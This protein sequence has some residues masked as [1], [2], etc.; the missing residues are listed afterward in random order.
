MK[1]NYKHQEIFKGLYL[2]VHPGQVVFLLGFEDAD[3]SCLLGTIAGFDSPTRG[4]IFFENKKITNDW[5]SSSKLL[6]IRRTGKQYLY[7]RVKQRITG[8]QEKSGK[9]QDADPLDIVGLKAA[10][11]SLCRGL[12]AQQRQRLS[13]A[14][15]LTLLPRL[16]LVDGAIDDLPDADRTKI[17]KS[18][19]SSAHKN[20]MAVLYATHHAQD[21]LAFGDQTA[22]LA[23]GRILQQ[24]TPMNVYKQPG[25]AACAQLTGECILL[26]GKATAVKDETVF[27]DVA[28]LGFTCF[29]ENWISPGEPL[30]ICLRPEHIFWGHEANPG[31]LTNVSAILREHTKVPGGHRVTFELKNGIQIAV[32]LKKPAAKL[33]VNDHCLLWFDTKNSALIP[34]QS[35]MDEDNK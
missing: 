23:N 14:Q 30:L 32:T 10:E 6:Y 35:N 17:L 22:I 15:A 9:A 33:A 34:C 13:L 3:K 20:G 11:D 4:D 19:I 16:L 21:A 1:K 7:G 24:D 27:V 29:S 26:Q 12:T 18:L 8:W 2:D 28:G 5:I 31:Y 25:S